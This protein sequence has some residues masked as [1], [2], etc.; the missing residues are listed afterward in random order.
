MQSTIREKSKKDLLHIMINANGTHKVL[1]KT[2]GFLPNLSVS[3]PLGTSTGPVARLDE[4]DGS[5]PYI[6]GSACV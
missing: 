1:R 6:V 2:R 5:N 3:F 4:I